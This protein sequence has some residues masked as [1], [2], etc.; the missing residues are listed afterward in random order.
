MNEETGDEITKGYSIEFRGENVIEKIEDGKY[1][2]KSKITY[3]S[4]CSYEIKVL[5]TN[6]PGYESVIGQKFYTEILETAKIDKLIKIRSKGEEWKTLVL[7][8]VEE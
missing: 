8:K 6:I 4:E 2:L 7:R 1:Y 3:T 5:E